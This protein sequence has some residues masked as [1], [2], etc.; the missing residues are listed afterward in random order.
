MPHKQLGILILRPVTGVGVDDELRIRHLLLND[1]G[2][3][4]GHDQVVT[5]VHH[6]RWLLDRLEI[7]IRALF[8]TPHLSIA[9]TWAGETLSF[10]SGSRP[11]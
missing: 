10:T 2:V 4:R 1:E 8:W 5:A 6:E 3:D 9:S 11:S 7:V